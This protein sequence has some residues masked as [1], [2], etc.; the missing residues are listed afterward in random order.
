MLSEI[1][2]QAKNV[3]SKMGYPPMSDE[4]WRYTNTKSFS[5]CKSQIK[6]SDFKSIN[7]GKI[8]S[9][10]N[11]ILCN[12][13]IAEGIDKNIQGLTLLNLEKHNSSVGLAKFSQISDYHHS[14]VIAH[15]TSEF[16]DVIHLSIGAD[17]NSDVPI[18]IVSIAQNLEDNHIIFPR[19]YIH[20][21]ASSNSKI[22]IQHINNNALGAAN[23]VSEFYCEESSAIEVI[24]VSNIKNHKFI[25]SI[26]FNQEDNSKIKFLSTAFGGELYRSNIDININGKNCDNQFGVLILGSEH[27]HIDYHTNINHLSGHSI[28]NFLCRSMLKDSANG[29][30]NGKILVSQG[31]SG[32]NARLNN[33]NLLLSDKSQMQSNPQLEINCKDVKCSHGSTTGNIDKDALF[34]LRSRGIDKTEAKE[35]LIE[36]FISK[37]LASFDCELLSLGEKVKKWIQL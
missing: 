33:N 5:N 16:T 8:D 15:N 36:G 28:S 3:F 22:F 35:I 34:Y 27:D 25:D 37:L 13:Q 1:Q 7:S 6:Q 31:A 14:G 9:A 21:K 11:I 10:T 26:F 19:I 29:I 18:N 4:N 2:K 20:A 23:S 17:Y 24:H 30:F 12:G 32:T